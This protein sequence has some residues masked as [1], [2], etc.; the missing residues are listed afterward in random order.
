[1]RFI[2][3]NQPVFI[4]DEDYD[5]IKD[6]TWHLIKSNNTFY[7]Q[8]YIKGSKTGGK[9]AKYVYLHRLVFHAP[10]GIEIDH[11]NHNGLDCRKSNLRLIS[12]AG[13]SRNRLMRNKTG[14]KGVRS[15]GN[16]F[17]SK[18]TIEGKCIYLGSYKTPEQAGQAYQKA[19][20]EQIQKEIISA[21]L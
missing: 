9:T 4:D 7:A 8:A 19:F 12:R 15:K 16:R 5:L 6:Y 3:N 14:F 10:D 18:I 1:M 11:K 2:I 21:N 17:E 13:N 20:D